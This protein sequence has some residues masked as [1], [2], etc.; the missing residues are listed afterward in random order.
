MFTDLTFKDSVICVIIVVGLLGLSAL[1]LKQGA[2]RA[3]DLEATRQAIVEEAI[4]ADA[5]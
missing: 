5:E 4:A 1:R 2:V 3:E